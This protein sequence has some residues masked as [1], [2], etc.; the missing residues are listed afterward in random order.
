MP[1]SNTELRDLYIHV[2]NL[3]AHYRLPNILSD[4]RALP[5]TP[6]SSP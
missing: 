4:H 2:G 1:M 3:L 6:S 5:A